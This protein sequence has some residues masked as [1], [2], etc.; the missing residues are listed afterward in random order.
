MVIDNQN[1]RIH[2]HRG[3]KQHRVVPYCVLR[4][5]TLDVLRSKLR[6]QPKVIWVLCQWLAQDALGSY[7]GIV[8]VQGVFSHVELEGQVLTVRQEGVRPANTVLSESVD[9]GH[10]ILAVGVVE[11]FE[12]P[13]ARVELTQFTIRL[14]Q[15]NEVF[16]EEGANVV[17][18]AWGQSATCQSSILGSSKPSVLV[19]HRFR[20]LADGAVKAVA[21]VHIHSHLVAQEIS[22]ARNHQRA[23]VLR[24]AQHGRTRAVGNS[25]ELGHVVVAVARG[26]R[27]SVVYG[28]VDAAVRRHI[29]DTVARAVVHKDDFMHVG[30]NAI[31]E[32]CKVHGRCSLL[33]LLIEA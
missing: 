16:V 18:R 11:I 3:F 31:R 2:H 29:H 12:Q 7:D 23:V 15:S 30:M 28:P 24:S 6:V 33:R 8:K 25:I 5:Q 20:D 19:T 13:G 22:I 26:V 32:S 9:E 21:T 14:I 4:H 1:S 27:V 17:H 10:V